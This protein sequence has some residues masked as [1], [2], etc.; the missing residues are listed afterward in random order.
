MRR[1]L[2]QSA[3]IVSL[4]LIM[5]ACNLSINGVIYS[6]ISNYVGQFE[7]GTTV[8][9]SLSGMVLYQ[10]YQN[11][12]TLNE[13]T[14]INVTPYL[15]QIAW[16]P[17]SAPSGAYILHNNGNI[18][19]QEG[20]IYDQKYADGIAI[21]D[22]QL[23]V[24]VSPDGNKLCKWANERYLVPGINYVQDAL[25]TDMEGV[26]NTDAW[27]DRYESSVSSVLNYAPGW[28]R[29]YRSSRTYYLGASGE[30]KIVYKYKDGVDNLLNVI[31]GEQMP[32]RVWTSTQ[33]TEKSA[34]T[35]NWDTGQFGTQ[36]KDSET[37]SNAS[38]ARPFRRL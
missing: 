17:E 7:A 21:I 5:P 30:W 26:S 34:V 13:D 36:I 25:D 38:R 10:D 6:S 22:P 24:L 29:S 3:R 2:I 16:L 35:M 1:R 14:V 8:S 32:D 27:M 37:G 20:W 33:G 12:I 19:S 31:G 28:C 18:Y 15:K 9:Y 11:Q 4:T 23:R